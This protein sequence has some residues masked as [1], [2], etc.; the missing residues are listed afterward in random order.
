MQKLLDMPKCL[1]KMTNNKGNQV[2]KDIKS[3]I[4]QLLQG[5]EGQQTIYI[6]QHVISCVVE[7]KL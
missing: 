2:S 1:C 5:S 6:D 3:G 7:L 4:Y